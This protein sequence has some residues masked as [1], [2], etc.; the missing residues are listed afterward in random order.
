[1]IKHS[2]YHRGNIYLSGSMQHAP[3][4]QLG[5]TWREQCARQL[6]DMKYFPLD[7]TD[8]D[9]AYT[10]QHGDLYHSFNSKPEHHLQMKSNLRKHFVFTDLELIEK[11]SDALILLYDEGVR[12]GAGTISEAQHAYNLGIPIFI[13]SAYEDWHK[14][15]PGWLLSLSTK[16][17][18]N[19][20]FLFDYLNDLPQ[21]I[22]K[23]DVYGNRS[24][25]AQYLCSLCGS[26]F[27]KTK[28]HF[29]ST[30]SPCYCSGCVD[31]VTTTFENH[32][33]RYEFFL[34]YLE[35]ESKEE[36]HR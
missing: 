18:E 31:V 34:E 25:G 7:I 14:E 1:M 2:K 23:R 16:V 36:D 29:V 9:I 5:G 26:P 22:L 11:D 33:D 12:R 6:K 32:K 3:D 24:A 20:D 17:F 21:G 35:E 28:H 15:I 10:E 8:M 4:G 19:F 13:V 30:I 27:V